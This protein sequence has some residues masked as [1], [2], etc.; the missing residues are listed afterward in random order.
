MFG[1][2][3]AWALFA[4]VVL[5]L[6]T[7]ALWWR[8]APDLPRYAPAPSWDLVDQ[9]DTPRST[10]E[11]RGQVYLVNFIFTRCPDVCPMLSSK[12]AR[13]LEQ[14]PEQPLGGVPIRMVSVTVDPSHDTPQVLAEYAARWQADP[15]RWFFL[16]GEPDR[17]RAV[18]DG[19]QQLADRGPDGPGGIPN[20]AHSERFLLIDADG[21]I[22]GFYRSDD[23][24]LDQLRRDA[25][26]LARAGGV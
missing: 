19:Y 22:R 14:L 20:I 10:L 12:A 18:I 5:G 25:T 17:V 1:R 26:R 23:G 9:S 24:G 8:T 21:V 6:P 13:L 4:L 15:A 11:L 16:T 2:P 7:L 3:L